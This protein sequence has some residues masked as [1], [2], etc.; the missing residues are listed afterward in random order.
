MP[1]VM[2]RKKYGHTASAIKGNNKITACSKVDFST[3]NSGNF[4]M[5]MGDD[6]F[7]KIINKEKFVYA[8]DAAVI[9]ANKIQVN[10]NA[11]MHL[12]VDDDIDISYKNYEVT[13]ASVNQGGEG[14][15]Q[16]DLISVDGGVCKYN[17]IDEIDIPV[18]L[19]VEEVDSDGGIVSVN[20]VN[21][22]LYSE[23]PSDESDV[24]SGSGSG[25]SL[26]LTTK[27]LSTSV[28]ESRGISSIELDGDKSVITINHAVAPRVKEISIRV[29]KW[30]LTLASA[31]AGQQDKLNVPYDIIKDFTPHCNLPLI[32]S[33]MA[34]NHLV[35]NEAMAIIDQRLK[36]LEDK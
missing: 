5:L 9:E 30:Q 8:Q 16:G 4:I 36:D 6:V 35:Y 21:K 17:S 7:Y 14:Y 26:S 25:A 19:S 3:I 20:L 10:E 29:E 2:I 13:E 18:K 32:N 1:P 15:E 33:N 23:P 22:G 24:S 31:Y 34:T 12:N 27:L 11:L 28:V